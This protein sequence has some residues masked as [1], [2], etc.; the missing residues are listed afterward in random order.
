[1]FLLLFDLYS[2]ESDLLISMN[3]TKVNLFITF[4]FFFNH[5]N[6]ILLIE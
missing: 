1:M 5:I 3:I 2:I 6:K 4:S